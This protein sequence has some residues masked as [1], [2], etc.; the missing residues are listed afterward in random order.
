MLRFLKAHLILSSLSVPL[1]LQHF[2]DLVIGLANNSL[3]LLLHTLLHV[4][5]V[6]LLPFQLL[7]SEQLLE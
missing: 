3:I 4:G 1:H 7:T 5:L 6:D 2:R